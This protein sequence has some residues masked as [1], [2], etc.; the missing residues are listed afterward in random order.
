M[1]EGSRLDR[2]YKRLVIEMNVPCVDEN[3]YVMSLQNRDIPFKTQL[4]TSDNQHS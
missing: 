3:L 4:S 1:A 2:E